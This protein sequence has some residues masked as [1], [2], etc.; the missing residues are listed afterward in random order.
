MYLYKIIML[1]TLNIYKFHFYCFV[2]FIQV[3]FLGK[4]KKLRSM[5]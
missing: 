4:E 2:I 1:Y 3:L 5:N